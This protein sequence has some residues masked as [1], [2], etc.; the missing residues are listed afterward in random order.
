MDVRN[1]AILLKNSVREVE[2]GALRK[3]TSQIEPGSTI[4]TAA[5]VE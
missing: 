4:A 1:A 5:R 3:P 2:R